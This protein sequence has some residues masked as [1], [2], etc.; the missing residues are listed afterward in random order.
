MAKDYS[1]E[2]INKLKHLYQKLN[3]LRPRRIRRY[4]AG[5]EMTLDITTVFPAHQARIKIK[6]EDYIGGGYA[7]QVYR[8]SVINIQTPDKSLEGIQ[9]GGIYA[10]KILVP[11]SGFARFFRNFIYW[12]AFQGPFSLQVNPAALRAGALWQKIIRRGAKI[13]FGSE[14]AVVDSI[15]TFV[16]TVLGSCGE[17]SEWI[18]GRMWRFEVDD[19]LDARKKWKPGH[20]DN[21]LGSPEYRAKKE[22]M[23]KMVDLLHDMGAPELARQ[24]EWWTCK[25]QPNAL[26]RINFN[27]NP[28]AGHV[29]VDFRAGLALLPL[30]PMCPAD[31]WLILKGIGRGSLV[32]FDRG[33]LNHLKEFI[34]NHQKEFQ[35]M[36]T[37]VE[38]LAEK[39][40]LYRNSLPDISHHHIKLLYS[41]KLWSGILAGSIDSWKI[42]NN[43]DQKTY[44]NLKE[45]CCKAMLY[46][47][48]GLFPFLGSKLR[49]LA[50]N[51]PFRRHYRQ[52]FTK[53]AYFRRAVRAH[54]LEKLIRWHRD[55]RISASRAEQMAEHPARY[56]THLPL[57]ILPAGLHRFLSDRKQFLKSLDNIFR[58]P[59]RLYFRAEEREQWLRDMIAQGRTKGM[60]TEEEADRINTQIK[61]PFI[62]KYLKSLAVHVCTLPV[63]QI[64]SV[65]VAIIY[66]RLHPELSWQQASVHAGII[67]G[68]FQVTPISPGSLVRGL[69]VTYLVIREKNFQD[70]SIAFSLSYFKY[71]G[72]LAFP[73]QMA[74]RYPDIARFMAGHWATNAVHIVPVFGERGA[75]L[76]HTVF[77]LFYNYPLTIRRRMQLR[78]EKRQMLRS[79]SWHV[80]LV[81]PASLLVMSL[82]G[83]LYHQITGHFPAIGDFW[84]GIIWIPGIAAAAATAWARG[85]SLN[86]RFLISIVT[87]ASI[88]LF[89]PFIQ[90]FLSLYLSP[91]YEKTISFSQ[92]AGDAALAALWQIFLFSLIAAIGA[93]LFE[94]RKI[95]K[96]T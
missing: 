24:Y 58:R 43:I 9:T 41:K 13:R 60:L 6:I 96:T 35:D 44:T 5:D 4:D 40:T 14:K 79:R 49:K 76:E 47:L 42:K 38:E 56:L 32:Q 85:M 25:S 53:W 61:E 68:L 21:N 71:I 91:E 52:I 82:L 70:Y 92:M 19:N 80:F 30:L 16:D 90:K 12:L 63:T 78:K 69:Y 29:A 57:S 45:N 62:Q 46:Y 39:E 33:N 8:I 37:A 34:K 93:I 23:K 27:S 15:A 31:F 10:M 72:Y 48:L 1:I 73:I 20:A 26:K 36:E 84:W 7:G 81:I 64:I 95:R 77:D 50:G 74:Y 2:T 87:G 89:Y 59:I 86:K 88:G 3:I 18:E 51:E 28:K 66:V 17:I 75:L 55:G 94:T 11:V 22:F 54:V 83:L 67:L 65:L